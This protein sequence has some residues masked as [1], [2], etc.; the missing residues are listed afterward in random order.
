MNGYSGVGCLAMARLCG[1]MFGG[2][3]S[4]FRLSSVTQLMM[5][6]FSLSPGQRRPSALYWIPL[7]WRGIDGALV[8]GEGPQSTREGPQSTSGISL[9][10]ST[11]G[12]AFVVAT[13]N[14][15]EIVGSESISL[16]LKTQ[17]PLIRTFLSCLFDFC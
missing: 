16:K 5:F 11:S 4:G 8:D 2:K 7:L 12:K 6:L 15:P 9:P 10:Q 17:T 3:G 1:N 13:V 14:G